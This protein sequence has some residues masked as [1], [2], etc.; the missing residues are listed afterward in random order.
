MNKTKSNPISLTSLELEQIGTAIKNLTNILNKYEVKEEATTVS[1]KK[2]NV[3]FNKILKSSIQTHKNKTSNI[4]VL[5]IDGNWLLD[6]YTN[7]KNSHF[8]YQYDRVY[9]VLR[10]KF[11]LQTDEIQ[12]F[13][14]SL[15][16]TQYKMPGVTPEFQCNNI[17]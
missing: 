6:Y 16:E 2:F 11:S 1:Q 5:D 8:W 10:D 7:P 3:A 13:M 9:C 12:A 4:T 14:K 17:L 15:V